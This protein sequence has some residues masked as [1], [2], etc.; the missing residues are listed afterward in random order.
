MGSEVAVADGFFTQVISRKNKRS[1]KGKPAQSNDTA[2]ATT[3]AIAAANTTNT[4]GA[5]VECSENPVSATTSISEVKH[6]VSC[7]INCCG[8]VETIESLKLE[9]SQTK[10]ELKV[11]K[12]EGLSNTIGLSIQPISSEGLLQPNSPRSVGISSAISTST[13]S[14]TVTEPTRRPTKSYA[15]A[16]Y[17]A[18]TSPAIKN[19]HRNIVSVVYTDLQEKQRRANNILISGLNPTEYQDEKAVV[20]GMIWNAFG[21]NVTVKHCRRLGKRMPHQTQNLL[22]TLSSADDAAFPIKHA[23]MLRQSNNDFVRSNIFVNADLTP[24]EALAAYESRCARRQRRAEL[25]AKTARKQTSELTAVESVV[26]VSVGAT[27]PMESATRITLDP[28][29]PYFTPLVATADI[30]NSFE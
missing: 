16:V 20:T 26:G 28:T 30:H 14:N 13:Q 12:D 25:Q 6:L 2:T 5:T 17:T 4:N 18:A 1:R 24:A 11:M 15:A 29:T 23:R 3:S 8:S 21:K 27:V 9:L 22:V 7:S 10:A 19:F